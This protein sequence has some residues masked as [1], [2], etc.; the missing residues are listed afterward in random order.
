MRLLL[1]QPVLVSFAGYPRDAG[2]PEGRGALLSHAAA[3]QPR[4]VHQLLF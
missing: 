2:L 4:C 3:V 1:H